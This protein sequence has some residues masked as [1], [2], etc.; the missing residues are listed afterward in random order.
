[1]FVGADMVDVQP[2][3][4][5]SKV[6]CPSDNLYAFN[7]AVLFDREGHLLAKYH[8]IHLFGE[9]SKNLPPTEELV[10]VD[11]EIGRLGLQVCFDMIFKTPGHKL[12]SEHL[13]DTLVFPTWWFDE[14]PFLSSKW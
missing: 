13:I 11:T 12:A 7:T 6:K 4:N 2:C 1:M 5:S 9:M 8:K 3:H 14:S 10:V